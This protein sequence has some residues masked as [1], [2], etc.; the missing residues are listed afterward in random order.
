MR[1]EEI[2]VG[3]VYEGKTGTPRRV[4][5]VRLGRH[6]H[7]Y[8]VLYRNASGHERMPLVWNFAKWAVRAAP[9]SSEE[10]SKVIH[11]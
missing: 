8:E 4:L 9:P 1:A 3:K 5:E 2:E 7:P 10:A 11:D 6:G